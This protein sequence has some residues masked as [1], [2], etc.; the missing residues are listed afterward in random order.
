MWDTL[1]L[2]KDAIKIEK[3]LSEYVK[4]IIMEMTQIIHLEM[5]MKE[6][7]QPKM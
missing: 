5:E 4:M 3:C 1:G 2:L 7:S 6:F